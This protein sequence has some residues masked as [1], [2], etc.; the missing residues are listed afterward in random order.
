M[1]EQKFSDSSQRLGAAALDLLSDH[2]ELFVVELQEQKQHSSLQ[3]MWLSI[4][5]V[6]GFMLFLLLAALNS[7]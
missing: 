3:L 6:C 4:S 7:K 5:A 1:S 2:A